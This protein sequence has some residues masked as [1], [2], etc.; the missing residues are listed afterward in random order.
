[1]IKPTTKYGPT[2]KHHKFQVGDIVH[3]AN[4]FE[5]NLC[6]ILGITDYYRGRKNY[7]GN[8]YYMQDIVTGEIH[9]IMGAYCSIWTSSAAANLVVADWERKN[10]EVP[11]S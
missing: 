6:R 8:R 3:P 9:G 5:I 10:G 1:M 4:S 11:S 2:T 7:G